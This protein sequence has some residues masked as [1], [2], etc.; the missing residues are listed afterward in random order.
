MSTVKAKDCDRKISNSIFCWGAG[1]RIVTVQS[2][3]ETRLISSS[4]MRSPLVRRGTSPWAPIASDWRCLPSPTLWRTVA[5]CIS[6][7]ASKRATPGK[8]K[9]WVRSEEHTSELQSPDHL[10]CRLLLEKKKHITNQ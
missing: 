10:V 7:P 6:S 4:R 8:R 9:R 2:Y 1:K 5:S 3:Y